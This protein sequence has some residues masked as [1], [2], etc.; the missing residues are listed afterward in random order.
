MTIPKKT[1][2]VLKDK[3][4]DRPSNTYM[5]MQTDQP[6]A[7]YIEDDETKRELTL[8]FDDEPKGLQLTNM[9]SYGQP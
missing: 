9:S 2:C 3:A 5:D 8:K 7:Y 4:L 6:Q 1:K